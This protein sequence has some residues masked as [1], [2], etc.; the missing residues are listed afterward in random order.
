M[1][2][3]YARLPSFSELGV[4]D[5]LVLFT[6]RSISTLPLNAKRDSIL[7]EK[8]TVVHYTFEEAHVGIIISTWRSN[9]PISQLFLLSVHD[10]LWWLMIIKELATNAG[11]ALL[12][13][14]I[15]RT[16]CHIW[17]TYIQLFK[18]L[19]LLAAVAFEIWTNLRL[20]KRCSWPWWGHDGE[21]V[22]IFNKY[23]NCSAA[24]CWRH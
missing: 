11:K 15:K 10:L 20:K 21:I 17:H 24:H 22:V 5:K 1:Q 16:V 18:N 3:L 19:S 7:G 9:E 13:G 23:G 2:L 14:L 4:R 6:V 8:Q 12:P